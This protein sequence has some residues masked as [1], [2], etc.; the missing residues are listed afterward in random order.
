M[1]ESLDCARDVAYH[2]NVKTRTI[3]LRG[4]DVKASGVMTGGHNDNPGG[5]TLLDLR[6]YH[7]RKEEIEM[8]TKE[9]EELS[10]KLSQ[11]DNVRLEYQRLN[12][13]LIDAQRKLGQIKNNMKNSELGVVQKD[14]EEAKKNLAN[15]EQEV[16]INTELMAEMNQKVAR[17]E[18]MK[19]N[20]KN[21][22]EER[23]KEILANLQR[24]EKNLLMHK[25]KGEMAK[26]AVMQIAYITDSFE[27]ET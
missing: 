22:Q 9:Y 20:D 7:E 15:V 8:L 21:H 26:R 6:P 4:D 2:R 19:S 13:E 10:A 16:V 14:L 17:L 25:D 1:T 11:A 18:S 27:Q 3:S 5:S 23:K 12:E 24:A